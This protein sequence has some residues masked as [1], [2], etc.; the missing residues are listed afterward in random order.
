M[1][2]YKEIQ[3]ADGSGSTSFY[4]LSSACEAAYCWKRTA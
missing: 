4:R 2:I 1:A 3:K